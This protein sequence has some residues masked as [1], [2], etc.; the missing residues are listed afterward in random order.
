MALTITEAIRGYILADTTLA[1]KVTEVFPSIAQEGVAANYAV[2]KIVSGV[3][4]SKLDGATDQVAMRIEVT[5]WCKL[6]KDAELCANR[7]RAITKGFNGLMGSG[8]PQ[9]A[10]VATYGPRDLFNPD[11]RFYGC[12]Q[13][14]MATVDMSTVA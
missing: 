5:F 1:A 4:W 12:Q 3:S 7:W 9:I 14:T 2:T 8:G 10:V 13:D 11:T 6:H